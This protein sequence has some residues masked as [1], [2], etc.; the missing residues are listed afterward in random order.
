MS[1]GKILIT[2][3]SMS[4]NG[5]PGLAALTNAGYELLTPFP[6]K[7]PTEE[8]LLSILPQCAGFLAGVEKISSKVIEACPDL[9]V[10]SRN[11]VGID[12]V[13]R[14]SAEKMGIALKVTPGANSRGVAELTIGLMFSLIRAIPQVNSSVKSGKWERP[15][16]MEILGKTLGVIGTGMIG[17]E[18]ISMATGMGMKVLAYDLYPSDLLKDNEAVKYAPLEEVLAG[19]DIITLHCPAGDKPVI[20]NETLKLMKEGAWV[21]NTARSALVDDAAL[22]TAIEEG[23][24]SGYAVDAFDSEPPELNGLLRNDKVLTTAHIGGFTAESVD[25][26]TRAAVANILA[27]LE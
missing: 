3:R 11:G 25:R 15:K 13:D 14:E 27:V 2:P 23:K 4:K 6:G 17:R 1:K 12:N 22:L 8:E 5:H 16:G 10:I 18:V 21:V 19:S 20:G 9:K 7:M 24:V 26:A